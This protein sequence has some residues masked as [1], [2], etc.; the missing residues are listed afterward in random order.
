[1]G[2]VTKNAILLIDFT[3]QRRSDG[4]ERKDALL[5]AGSI[6]LRPIIMTTL[7]MIFGMLL[8]AL[9]LD[10]GSEMRVPMAYAIIGGLITS[11]LL[12]LLVVPIMYT[13]LDDFKGLFRKTCLKMVWANIILIIVVVVT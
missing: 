6:R 7:A 10:A 3:K 8:T 12:T 2:L 4:I 11:T 1:M 13:L 9:A 5:Q